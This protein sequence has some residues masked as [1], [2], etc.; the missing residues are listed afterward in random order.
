MFTQIVVFWTTFFLCPLRVGR[1]CMQSLALHFYNWGS[2]GP[3]QGDVRPP[4][5][6]AEQSDVAALALPLGPQL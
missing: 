3:A 4:V 6:D 1:T 5:M 2:W